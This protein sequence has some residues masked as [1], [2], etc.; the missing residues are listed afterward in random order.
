MTELKT[1]SSSEFG[2]VRIAEVDN[3]PWFCLLDVCRILGISNH[4]DV[5]NRLSEKG[6]D[7]IDTLTKGGKQSLLYV[8]ESNLYKTIFQ[9]KK[10][11]AEKF[12]D[13]VTDEVIP[14][15]RKNGGYIAGQE[16]ASP[17]M[18]LAN[19][20]I[21]AQNVIKANEQK[22][23]ELQP[24]ADYFDNLVDRNLLLNF[25]DTA[26]ELGIKR[27]EFIDW[28]INNKYCFRSKKN[29]IKP[30][31]AYSN[32]ATENTKYFEVK[33]WANDTHSGIQ[34][35][36]TPRGREVFRLLMIG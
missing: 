35:L 10:A 34:T 3:E 5:K 25:T 20:M 32:T 14:S 30:Y 28:L 9:S 33:E 16:N 22:I 21:V 6:V 13:W 11:E 4:K 17:E 1:F 19:A 27:K 2:E 8:N 15:I 29:D 18:I 12:T 26:K 23:A 7:T 31:A 36:I 24:K